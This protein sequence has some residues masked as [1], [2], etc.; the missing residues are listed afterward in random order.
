[1]VFSWRWDKYEFIG[2]VVDAE[3]VKGKITRT[4][5]IARRPCEV[6]VF[7]PINC[8]QPEVHRPS[9]IMIHVYVSAGQLLTEQQY[10]QPRNWPMQIGR[11][12]V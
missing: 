11:A 4:E 8:G 6:A 3:K 9:D 2:S 1:M 5:V 10:N 7:F 12:H